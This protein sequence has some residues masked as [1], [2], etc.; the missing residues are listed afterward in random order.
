MPARQRDALAA[1]LGH[2]VAAPQGRVTSAGVTTSVHALAS[3]RCTEDDVATLEGRPVAAV[4]GVLL[5]S[6]RSAKVYPR[7]DPA[8]PAGARLLGPRLLRDAG[9]PAAAAGCGRRRRGAASRAGRAAGG[10]DRR[11]AV[12]DRRPPRGPRV[13]P[14]ASRP[15]TPRAM[16]QAEP[17][18]PPPGGP[19]VILD[20]QDTPAP[21]LDFQWEQA[22]VPV[23]VPRPSVRWSGIGRAI[24]GLAVLGGGL[25]AL[26]AANFVLDQFGRGAVQGGRRSASSPAAWRC[27]APACGGDARAGLDPCR[28]PRPRGLRPRRPG[29]GEGRGAALG[30]IGRR[31]PRRCSRRSAARPASRNWAR[32]WKPALAALEAR[33]GALGAMPRCRASR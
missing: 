24:G 3:I 33:A 2:L 19:R 6:G 18:A 16:P 31:T 25:A 4:R 30:G 9:I 29:G 21:R 14:E 12:S 26:D 32:C 13:I 1:L 11:R 22:V 10:A 15:V 20:E 5:S 28:G 17:L 27:S 23:A 8:A 7:R